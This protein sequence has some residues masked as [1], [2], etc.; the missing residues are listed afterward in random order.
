MHLNE[1]VKSL[2]KEAREYL[3]SEEGVKGLIAAAYVM[4]NS[5]GSFIANFFV[6]VYKTKIPIKV[7]TKK[8]AALKWLEKFRK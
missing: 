7:F 8:E 6:S 2:Q 4:D 1:G 3:A 5:F